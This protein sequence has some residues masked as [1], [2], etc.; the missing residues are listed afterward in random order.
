MMRLKCIRGIWAI[1]MLFSLMASPLYAITPEEQL[2]NPALEDRARAISAQLRCLVCQNQSI[3]DSDADLARDLRLEVRSLLTEGY[4][5]DAIIAH[6]RATYGDYVLLNPPLGSAT[7]L[8]WAAPV[9]LIVLG[10]LGLWATRRHKPAQAG[11][12]SSKE[13][14][15]SPQD[16]TG[17]DDDQQSL[18]PKAVMVGLIA[19]AVVTSGLYA[20]LGRPDLDAQPLAGRQAEIADAGKE[21]AALSVSVQEA[22]DEAITA[23]GENPASVEAHLRLAM[24]AA[25]ASAHDIEL[26]AL[27]T[28]L[29]LTDDSPAIKAFKAEALSRKAGGLVTIPARD[30]IQEVLSAQPDEP[31]ALYLYGL[32]AYQDEDYLTALD[33]WTHLQSMVLPDSPLAARLTLSIADAAGRAGVPVPENTSPFAMANDMTDDERQE[34]ILGMVEGLEARLADTPD[35]PQG[36]DRLIRARQT[37]GDTDG[38][39]R[40]LVAAANTYPDQMER[41][42]VALE[43][44]I[45][46]QQEADYLDAALALLDRINT[47]SPRGPQFLFFAGHFA[48]ISGETDLAV[49]LWGELAAGLDDTNPIK[50][51]LEEQIA[52]LKKL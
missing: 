6:V 40:A 52:A 10:G 12:S 34:M 46:E 31:R 20:M 48:V 29:A 37:L 25:D 45:L 28:A 24:A 26:N 21:N 41:Q 49:S 5:D 27:D 11:P 35:N 2:D 43:A 32:A 19:I 1:S 4:S 33:R 3:D 36:W 14:D 17:M 15:I 38:L 47:L 22:L 51:E 13:A 44:I 9:I 39:L 50:R 23:A 42:V 8:L 16:A 30:L 7:G 18:S